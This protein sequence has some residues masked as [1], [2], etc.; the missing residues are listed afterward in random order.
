MINVLDR[1]PKTP[2]GSAS[3]PLAGVKVRQ[4]LNYAVNRKAVT[5]AI[6]GKYGAPTSEMGSSDG[7]AP[8]MEYTTRTTRPRRRHSWRGQATPTAS[9]STSHPKASSGPW[10]TPSSRRSPKSTAPSG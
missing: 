8:N 9:R 1:G 4:A 3:N 2:D 6:Y 10:P 5:V 7:F